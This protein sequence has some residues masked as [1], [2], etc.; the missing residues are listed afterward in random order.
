MGEAHRHRTAGAATIR[1]EPDATNEMHG[2]DGFLIHG[3]NATNDASEGC[4][5]VPRATRDQLR[6]GDRLEVIR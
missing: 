2:R 6:A 1:L 3:D 5:I 4:I